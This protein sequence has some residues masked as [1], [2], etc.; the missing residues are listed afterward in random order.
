MFIKL[1]PFKSKL[2]KHK[3]YCVLTCI[4]NLIDSINVN[5]KEWKVKQMFMLLI[6][7]LIL[8]D[9]IE[10]SLELSD[11]ELLCIDL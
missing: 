4:V 6:L 3:I 9:I 8:V 7:R 10:E 11:R 2:T 1:C 5:F